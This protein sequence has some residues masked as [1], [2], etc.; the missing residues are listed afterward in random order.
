MVDGLS[1][2]GKALGRAADRNPKRVMSD[3][4]G[5]DLP[6]FENMNENQRLG[7]GGPYDAYGATRL[8]LR[9]GRRQKQRQLNVDCSPAAPSTFALE[10]SSC[11]KMEGIL[12]G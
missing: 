2:S 6:T 8:S 7:I 12:A 9:T 4:T 11:L 5:T 1:I 10:N 3:G